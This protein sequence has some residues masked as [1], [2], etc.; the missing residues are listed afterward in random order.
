MAGNELRKP[1][2]PELIKTSFYLGVTSYGG[3]AIAAQLKRKLVDDKKWI[4]EKDFL[5]ALG[6][7]QMLPG[8]TFVTLMAYV[9]YGL[10]KITGALLLP[11]FF[12]L[13]AFAAIVALSYGY[14]HFAGLAYIVRIFS[15]LGAMV[16]ALLVNA[17]LSVGKSVFPGFSLK[18]YKGLL[19][20]AFVLVFSFRLKLEMVYLLA[21]AGGLGF[22]FYYF[23]GEFE[24]A[25]EQQRASP[26]AG[27]AVSAPS[28][29]SAR[30]AAAIIIAAIVILT[31]L[32][33]P[34]LGKI[35][36]SFFKIGMFSFGGYSSLPL[37]QHEAIAVHHWV[38][39]K[40]FTDGIAMGQITPGPI[41][42]SAA[43]IGFKAAGLTGAS[44]ATA[45]I[46]LPCVLLVILLY[47]LHG[48][49]TKL[50]WVKAF[51]KGILAGFIG[52][53]VSVTVSL[54]GV[55]LVSWQTW[56]IFALSAIALIKFRID[57]VWILLST[58]LVSLLIF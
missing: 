55:S 45:A 39:V 43:F 20:A 54:G 27:A 11:L 3:P 37:M 23:T 33:F 1:L 44:I 5:D 22:L 52:L 12:I 26:A 6:F 34:A 7:A 18:Y 28:G 58:V 14:F 47:E 41:L 16:I 8:A 40:E 36:V 15:G 56:A 19:I 25:R 38:S 46:F 21:A 17:V 31:L 42:I 29:R 48:E 13:P 4:G 35:F 51:V 49:L 30:Y 9:G 50:P 53:L 10:K 32:L 24:G 57:P 2:L